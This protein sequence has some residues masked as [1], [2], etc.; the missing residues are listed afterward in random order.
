MYEGQF[1]NDKKE[2]KGKLQEVAEHITYN[3]EFKDDRKNG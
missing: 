2:G 3:G 1:K